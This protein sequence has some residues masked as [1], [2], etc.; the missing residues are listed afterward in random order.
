MATASAAVCQVCGL[1][2]D[3]GDD[4]FG[5]TALSDPDG[6]PQTELPLEFGDALVDLPG[7]D[8]ETDWVGF[9]DGAVMHQRCARLAAVA[10]PHIVS[11]DD[12]ICVRV[13]ANDA[14]VRE[15]DKK[16]RPTYSVEDAI[17][18]P[19]P[20]TRTKEVAA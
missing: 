13:P 15:V 8:P 16:L 18:V 5:F 1:G 2:Y 20:G 7:M 11:R 6:N 9:L 3:Y 10:C 19:W 12:L 17:Y 4:A 14:T